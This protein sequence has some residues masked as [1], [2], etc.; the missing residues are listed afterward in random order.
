MPD[1]TSALT[2]YIPEAPV[3]LPTSPSSSLSSPLCD[4]PPRI[5]DHPSK[6]EDMLPKYK[7]ESDVEEKAANLIPRRP[8]S[9]NV[10]ALCSKAE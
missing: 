2:L 3:Y 9:S 10:Q 7:T 4:F 1:V 8:L 5:S 6:D